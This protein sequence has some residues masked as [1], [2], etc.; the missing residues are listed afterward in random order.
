MKLKD[1]GRFVS[2]KN[3]FSLFTNRHVEKLFILRI[4]WY[5]LNRCKCD[6]STYEPS[7]CKALV[8]VMMLRITHKS[9]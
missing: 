6:Y 5:S 7:T 2:G 3:V 9:T 1:H 4:V 8:D